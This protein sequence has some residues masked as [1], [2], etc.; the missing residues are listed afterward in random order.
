ML[1]VV[2]GHVVYFSFDTRDPGIIN[3]FDSIEIPLFFLIS[4][5][6]AYNGAPDDWNSKK[7]ITTLSRRFMVLVVPAIIFMI[8]WEIYILKGN[9]AVALFQS[10]KHGYWFTIT[11]FGF[12]LLYMLF[13]VAL[14]SIKRDNALTD[15]VL[16]LGG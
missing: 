10:Y 14:K 11:L 15:S 9:V 12:Y 8:I 4:G 7:I 6:F 1:F 2:M 13:I 3:V 5:F 16:L